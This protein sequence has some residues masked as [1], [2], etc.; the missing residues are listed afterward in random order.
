MIAAACGEILMPAKKSTRTVRKN[1]IEQLYRVLVEAIDDVVF[2]IGPDGRYRMFNERGLLPFGYKPSQVI[3]KTPTEAFGVEV[4]R[5]FETNNQRVVLGGKPV[6]LEE[7]L[8][9]GEKSVCYSTVLSPILGEGGEV[10][11]VVGVGRDVT[12][13]KKMAEELGNSAQRM[14]SIIDRRVRGERFIADLTQE[15]IRRQ[16]LADFFG[17]TMAK[18]GGLLEVSRAALFEYDPHRRL[19]SSSHEWIAPGVCPLQEVFQSSRVDAQPWAVG[20]LFAGRIIRITNAE[21]AP[22]SEFRSLLQSHNIVATLAVPIFIF[23]NPFGFLCFDECFR[24]RSWE[25]MEVELIEAA[26]RIIGTTVERRRLEQEVLRT[27]RLAATGRL[28]ASFAHE[29]NNPLQGI[30][31]HLDVIRDHM[32]RKYQ[33][34]IDFVVDGL[35]RI[36]RIIG[37]LLDLHRSGKHTAAMDVN[38]AVEEAF[39]L[40]ANQIAV[41]GCEVRWNLTKELPLIQADVEQLH[42]VFLNLILNAADSMERDGTLTLSTSQEE[43]TVV[44]AIE[45]TGIGIDEEHLPY[46]FEPFFSTKERAGTGLGLF[47]SHAI[48]ADHGGQIDVRSVKGRGTVMR[49]CLPIEGRCT[50]DSPGVR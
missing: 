24:Q 6:R 48:V 19:V 46:L 12:Q 10:A 33:R 21:E 27:E 11:L 39:H 40:V 2:V 22:S 4:G 44:I 34:N 7:W 26:G 37:R 31:L 15:A 16:P 35:K 17:T 47:I 20:E 45:D 28:A 13:L 8:T 1:S 42:Q 50:S 25:D 3:G 23:G 30:M 49:I 5:Q 38:G 43:D 29:I 41:K 9:F 32:D 18:L 36:A 14:E